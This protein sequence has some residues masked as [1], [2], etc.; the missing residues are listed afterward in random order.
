MKSAVFGFFYMKYI[1]FFVW[2]KITDFGFFFSITL[3][4]TL[5]ILLHVWSE[6]LWSRAPH[7]FWHF[8]LLVLPLH[9]KKW[10]SWENSK[11]WGNNVRW[12]NWTSLKDPI[13]SCF[14]TY[15]N[16]LLR[17]ISCLTWFF[18]N[19]KEVICFFLNSI[20]S[21]KCLTVFFF[22]E[23]SILSICTLEASSFHIILVYVVYWT[24]IG[25]K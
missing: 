13:Q 11:F 5:I 20:L 22:T 25:S 4:H 3:R 8:N 2:R 21:L 1:V 24:V 12:N 19:K 14:K 18:H 9:C 23:K 6:V 10:T 15:K 7:Y 17:I 16:H